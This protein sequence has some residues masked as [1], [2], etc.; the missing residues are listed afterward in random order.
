MLLVRPWHVR[1]ALLQQERER[2]LAVVSSGDTRVQYRR[3][4][5]NW[6]TKTKSGL[7]L[8]F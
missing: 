1:P 6:Y 8:I 2:E 4:G 3:G 5:I 7:L